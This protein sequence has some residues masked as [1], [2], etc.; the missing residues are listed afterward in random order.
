MSGYIGN[1]R[2]SSLVSLNDVE[3]GTGVSFPTFVGMIS[4]FSILTS[5]GTP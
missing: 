5:Q 2:S 4:F 3:I 1:K